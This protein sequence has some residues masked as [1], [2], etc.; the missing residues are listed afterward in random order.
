MRDVLRE[1]GLR[2]GRRAYESVQPE[3]LPRELS[4]RVS[5]H[6]KSRSVQVRR[7][8]LLGVIDPVICSDAPAGA[9]G[10]P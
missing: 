7:S 5:A 4:K 2:R 6:S 8:L 9:S 10:L 1:L 3:R